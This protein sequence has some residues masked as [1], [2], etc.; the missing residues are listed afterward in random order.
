MS[1]ADFR[2]EV[3]KLLAPLDAFPFESALM[4]AKTIGVPDI[5]FAGGFIE[6]K[7]LKAW[8]KRT[9]TPVKI[10]HYTDEQ[11]EWARRRTA[12]GED[13]WFMLKVRS[14]WL[15]LDSDGSSRIGEMNKQELIEACRAYWPTKPTS[16]QLCSILRPY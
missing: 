8:P 15:L 11:R 14:E 9:D 3:V 12:A 4:T 10:P 13:V 1:E 7:I 6:L 5:N 2:R 16:D